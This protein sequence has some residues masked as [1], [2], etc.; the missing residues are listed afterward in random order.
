MPSAIVQK[1]I[2]HTA[3]NPPFKTAFKQPLD[4]AH[5]TGLDAFKTYNIHTANDYI[6]NMDEHLKWI[7]IENKTGRNVYEHIC[8]FYFILDLP[9][10]REFQSPID[11]ASKFPWRWLS[12]WL[13]EYALDVGKWMDTPSRSPQRV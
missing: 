9:P 2:H 6:R 4:L 1:L 3:E 7:P 10:V 5:A 8:L 13:I 11:P 12:E